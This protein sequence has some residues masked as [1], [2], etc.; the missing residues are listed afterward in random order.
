MLNE[1]IDISLIPKDL[2]RLN[3]FDLFFWF[4]SQLMNGLEHAHAKRVLHLD[5]KPKNILLDVTGK[6]KLADFNVSL[7]TQNKEQ[8]GIIGLM[9]GT[10]DFM[11]DEQAAALKTSS[12]DYLQNARE[13]WD[14]YSLGR[15]FQYLY[16]KTLKPADHS[17]LWFVDFDT[18]KFLR[19][20]Q[21]DQSTRT[22][23]TSRTLKRIEQKKSI[24]QSLPILPYKYQ[25]LVRFDVL[26]L[27]ALLAVIFPQFAG[28]IVN[29]SYNYFMIVD[30]L[31]DAHR[32]LFTNLLGIYN[33]IIYGLAIVV[34]FSPW[35]RFARAYK[36]AIITGTLPEQ[37]DT[38]RR[39]AISLP[40]HVRR[41]IAAAWLS[42]A[43]FFPAVLYI[44][45]G[46][47]DLFA[48]A[49]FLASF[50]LAWFIAATYSHL[51]LSA[52][53]LRCFYAVLWNPF[54]S[55]ESTQAEL[56]EARIDENFYTLSAVVTPLI[57]ACLLI[58]FEPIAS[59]ATLYKMFILLFITAGIMGAVQALYIRDYIIKIRASLL[60]PK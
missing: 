35:V 36:Q 38:L 12:A 13:F 16:S 21:T 43:V 34:G 27:S 22:V 60:S 49:Q 9:G 37:S 11:S 26:T 48:V 30:I 29:I 54:S 3:S 24:I 47:F 39:H 41:T 2:S 45:A 50:V 1:D 14:L 57:G 55:K 23:D 17:D 19:E 42:S 5:I 58:A 4:A 53:I 8:L 56:K 31:D 46:P 40:K 6:P 51:V 52:L 15:I 44:V 10:K 28:S 20:M 7:V 33:P 59:K 32:T 25:K 18:K